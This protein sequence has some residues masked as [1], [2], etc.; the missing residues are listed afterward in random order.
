MRYT[1]IMK[2]SFF[3]FLI[4]FVFLSAGFGQ[5]QILLQEKKIDKLLNTKGLVDANGNKVNIYE[6]F[7]CKKTYISDSAKGIYFMFS[8]YPVLKVKSETVSS[9]FV[10]V[11]SNEERII[12]P[13]VNSDG[14]TLLPLWDPKTW[15]GYDYIKFDNYGRA[16]FSAIN[17]Q[18]QESGVALFNPETASTVFFPLSASNYTVL[19]FEISED[20]RYLLVQQG[21]KKTDGS[22]N[23]KFN[24]ILYDTKK[25]GAGEPLFEFR[26]DHITRIHF[27]S[28]DKG[29]YFLTYYRDDKNLSGAYVLFPKDGEYSPKEM[30]FYP[31]SDNLNLDY[32]HSILVKDSSNQKFYA[33]FYTDWGES[34]VYEVTFYQNYLE[35]SVPVYL[36]TVRLKSNKGEIL[37]KQNALGIS[38]FNT[39]SKYYSLSEEKITSYRSEKDYNEKLDEAMFKAGEFTSNLEYVNS[40]LKK[41]NIFLVIFASFLFVSLFILLHLN[42][43]ELRKKR[44]GL[45]QKQIRLIQENEKARISREIHDTIVQDL[46]AVRVQAENLDVNDKNNQ[47]SLIEE[48]TKLIVKLRNICYSLT[49]AELDTENEAG[50]KTELVSIIDTLCRQFNSKTNIPCSVQMEENFSFPVFSK[51]VST[52]IIRVFQEILNNIEKHSYATKVS[53]L[54]R[55]KTEENK[56]YLVIFVID[57]GVGCDLEKIGK[58]KGNTHFGIRNMK[59]RMNQIGAQIEFFSMPE[60][61][62]KVKLVVEI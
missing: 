16:F 29:F 36:E 9:P 2:K 61:G 49:P 62:M 50:N 20:G 15:C 25:S 48:I 41:R 14:K 8:N 1:K 30:L 40:R 51:D 55:S 18:T 22:L 23:D 52:N 45:E 11:C 38:I 10:Y 39:S 53:V 60:E 33:A 47:Q 46:R 17:T 35:F 44:N 12:N 31:Y 27:N 59:D 32:E 28:N 21:E 6:I 3:I 5:N 56:K 13:L 54:I 24:I 19:D 42:I 58:L 7:R 43:R 4:F 26:K 57:D 37:L 34:P